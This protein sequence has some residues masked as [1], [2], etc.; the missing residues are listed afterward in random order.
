MISAQTLA[1]AV[2][3]G[4]DVYYEN[5]GGEIGDEVFKHLNTHARI[6]VCGAISSYNHPEEDIGPRIQGT[7]IKKQAMMRGFLVAEFADDFKMQA[8]NSLNGYKRVRLRLK[9]L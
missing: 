2:P 6:P 3:D 7:L 4:I 8:N 1:D 9:Y 5:V